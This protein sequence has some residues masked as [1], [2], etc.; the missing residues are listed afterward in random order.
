ML[1]F[2][3]W[4]KLVSSQSQASDSDRRLY[5]VFVTRATLKPHL[6][7]PSESGWRLQPM[8]RGES[9]TVFLPRLGHMGGIHYTGWIHWC[10]LHSHIRG[11]T[12][13][14]HSVSQSGLERNRPGLPA[15]SQHWRKQDFKPPDDHSQQARHSQPSSL[16]SRCGRWCVAEK[17]FPAGLVEIPTPGIH[18]HGVVWGC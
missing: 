17:P 11:M 10:A 1:L 7:P 2:E 6:S 15:G 3:R 13:L 16:P 14:S 5:E 12:T 9:H 4:G 8:Q 18:E